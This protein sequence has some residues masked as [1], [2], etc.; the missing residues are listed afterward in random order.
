M[1]SQILFLIVLL[2]LISSC[3]SNKQLI[4]LNDAN[5]WNKTKINLTHFENKIQ[6]GD[7]LKIDIKS[8]ISEAA[9]PY[10]SLKLQ[11]NIQNI[12]ILRLEGYLV[13][14]SGYV[15]LP[16]LGGV[17]AFDLTSFDLERKIK[18]LL[19]ENNHLVDPSVKI[20]R[21]NSKFTVLGEVKNPGTFN[22]FDE[23]ITLFQAL[24]YAGDLTVDGKRNDI[25]LI[26]E[27]NGFRSIYKI[28]INSSEMLKESIYQ[29]KNNDVI[30]VNPTFSK[31]KSAGFIGSPGSIASM[32]S[33]LLSI[34]LLIINN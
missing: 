7:I 29:I 17:I 14:P 31:V 2:I 21:V 30:I 10:N 34:T 4:Y 24:G 16:V 25:S 8:V 12:D 22:Y 18:K 19:L 27:E 23:K 1:K 5:Q 33:I 32:A 6:I 11:T 20:R 3:T 26:R 15:H 13:D 9:L 28:N